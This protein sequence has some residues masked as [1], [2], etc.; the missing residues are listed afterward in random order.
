[1]KTW[2]SDESSVNDS[3]N[4]FLGQGRY[5]IADGSKNDLGYKPSLVRELLC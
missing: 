2:S 5:I 4:A 3:I 1:M